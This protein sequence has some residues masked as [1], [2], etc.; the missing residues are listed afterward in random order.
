MIQAGSTVRHRPTG[1]DWFVLGV[2]KTDDR[3]CVA[4]WPPTMALLS[5]CELIETGVGLTEAEI[6]Y[7]NK[8]FGYN[9]ELHIVGGSNHDKLR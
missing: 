8:T 4:G 9:W 6:N 7:R 1:E 2:N 5:D 3:I